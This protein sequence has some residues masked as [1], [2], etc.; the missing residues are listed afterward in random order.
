MHGVYVGECPWVEPSERALSDEDYAVVCGPGCEPIFALRLYV[1]DENRTTP[2]FV[3]C[4]PEER[5]LPDY[6]E[7]QRGCLLGPADGEPYYFPSARY[8]ARMLE[9]G[10]ERC[11]EPASDIY[12]RRSST[13]GGEDDGEP[14]VPTIVGE[15]PYGCPIVKPDPCTGTDTEYA[16]VCGDGCRAVYANSAAQNAPLWFVGCRLDEGRACVDI[17]WDYP[18]CVVDPF[19]LETFEIG[20]CHWVPIQRCWSYCAEGFGSPDPSPDYCP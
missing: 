18:L 9:L 17:D 2:S 10:W 15:D 6:Y 13:C 8:R 3:G 7:V 11:Q 16:T 19:G 5:A 1:S 20:L 14:F 12:P 4:A